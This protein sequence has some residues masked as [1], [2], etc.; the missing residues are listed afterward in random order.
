MTCSGLGVGFRVAME[1]VAQELLAAMQQALSSAPSGGMR[2]GP[3]YGG[4]GALTG[5]P[6]THGTASMPPVPVHVAS[7]SPAAAAA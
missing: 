6:P 7:V 4:P 5:G 1:Q 3:F 2:G